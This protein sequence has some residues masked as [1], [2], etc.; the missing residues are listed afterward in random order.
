MAKGDSIFA[1]FVRP[2]YE[3]SGLGRAVLAEPEKWL[4]RRGEEDIWLTTDADPNIRAHGFY[5]RCGWLRCK[6]YDNGEVKY[7]K[8]RPD[9]ALE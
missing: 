6:L 1:V 8:H 2:E 3:A 4:W 5:E 7:V 9:S